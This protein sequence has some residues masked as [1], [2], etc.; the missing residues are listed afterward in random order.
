MERGLAQRN[1]SQ[2]ESI[3]PGSFWVS[4][5]SSV[6]MGSMGTESSLPSSG[7]GNIHS[8]PGIVKF[9]TG[10]LIASSVMRSCRSGNPGI[11]ISLKPGVI[12]FG[13][14]G[15]ALMLGSCVDELV[16]RTG[17]CI[18]GGL[19][20]EQIAESPELVGIYGMPELPGTSARVTAEFRVDEE[21][22]KV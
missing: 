2:K 16:S 9:S 21:L 19:D 1:C 14:E 12:A 15:T 4:S 5:V 8:G 3:I 18:S 22:S 13:T 11:L 10:I 20:D 7:R 6:S 17:R